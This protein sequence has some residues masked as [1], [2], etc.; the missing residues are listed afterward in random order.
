MKR[1][2]RM[3]GFLAMYLVITMCAAMLPV[4]AFAAEVVSQEIGGGE[5]TGLTAPEEGKM[6]F[7]TDFEATDALSVFNLYKN[8]SSTTDRGTIEL[9]SDEDSAHGQTVELVRKGRMGVRLG[10]DKSG[11]ALTVTSK[12]SS[13]VYEVDIKIK[14]LA[15]TNFTGW[16]RKP[17]TSGTGTSNKYSYIFSVENGK[18]KGRNSG[19]Y[20]ELASLNADTW[21]TIT[22]VQNYGTGYRD[23]Y[24]NGQRITTDNQLKIE[25]EYADGAADVNVF[26]IEC[27]E[28]AAA[29]YNAE[30]N[31]DAFRIDNLKI[32]EGTVPIA[33]TGGDGGDPGGDSGNQGGDGDQGGVTTT[34]RAPVEGTKLFLADFNEYN[35]FTIRTVGG[36]I[37]LV[38][39][40]DTSRGKVAEIQRTQTGDLR[41][42]ISGN[43]SAVATDASSVVYEFDLNLADLEATIFSFQLRKKVDG[44]SKYS[45]P[46]YVENGSLKIRNGAVAFDA[47]TPLQSLEKDTWY[48]IAIVQNYETGYRDVYVNGTKVSADNTFVIEPEYANGSTNGTTDVELARIECSSTTDHF[49]LD[50][51]R[52]YEG[53]APYTGEL[54]EKEV[55]EEKITIDLTKSVF[56]AEALKNLWGNE[57]LDTLLQGYV[58][59]HTRSGVVYHGGTKTVLDT[60][61]VK[62]DDGFLVVLEEIC[63]ALGLPSEVNGTTATVQGQSISVMHEDGKIWVNA[64]A[65]LG[66]YGTVVAD[67][68]ET[69]KS[70]G[71]L[72]AGSTAFSWPSSSDTAGADLKTLGSRSMLQNLNEY[73]FLE[74]PK[75]ADI[76]SLYEGSDVKGQHPRIQATAADFNKIKNEVQTNTQIN[77]WYQQLITA[78]DYLV[79]VNTTPLK[80]EFRDGVRLLYVSRDMLDHMYT[81]G[82]AYQLTGE[83]KYADRAWIDLEAVSKFQDWHPQHGLD[84]VEMSAAVAIGYDWM[85]HGL[86]QDQRSVVEKGM[87]NHCFTLACDGYQ[88]WG[89]TFSAAVLQDGN[90]NVVV[91]AGFLMG[92]LAFM[93]VYPEESAFITSGAIRAVEGMLIEFGPDGAWKEGPNY[94][95]Y[96]MQYTAKLL[97]TLDSVFGTCFSLDK[98]E[99]LSTAANYILDMQ[100]DRGLFDYGDSSPSHYYVPEIF[101]LSNKYDKAELSSTLMDLTQ[102]KMLD[103]ENV[104]LSMLW[105]DTAIS[106]IE[107]SLPLDNA[108]WSEG[109]ASFRD[110]W[111]EGATAYVGIHG[112]K[113]NV[114]HA[115]V[116]AGTFVYDYAGVRWA[117]EIGRTPYDTSVTSNRAEDS[118]RWLLYNSKAEAHNTLVI[119]PD[120]TAGQKINATAPL[121]RFENGNKGG[122][123]V[124]DLSENY[125]DHATSAIRG[126]FFT[127]DRTSLVVRDEITLSKADS[128]VYWFMQT[129]ADVEIAADGKSAI[130]SQSGQEMKLEYVTTGNGTA[131]LSFGPSTRALLGS[132]S[133]LAGTSEASKDVESPGVNRIA[134]KVSGASEDMT[135]TVKL[136]PKNAK[137]TALGEYNK[138]I[139]SWTIPEGEIAARP[140]VQSV[141]MDGR[142][143]VFD[144]AKKATFLCVEGAYNTIPSPMVTVDEAKFTYSVTNAETTDG[145]TVTILVKDKD[146]PEIVTSYTIVLEEIPVAVTPNG[147]AG[148]ALQVIAA[149]ASAEPEASNGYVAWK[150]L[151]QDT[152]SR[153]TSQGIANWILL[154]LEKESEVDNLVVL[155]KN[156][157]KR[158]TYFNVS[159]STDGENF[160]VIY[161]GASAGTMLGNEEAYEQFALGGV[162]AKYIKIGCNGNSAQG[163]ISGWNNIGEIVFTGTEKYVEPS[164]TPTPEAS[165]SP[166]PTPTPEA[167][168][169]PSPTPTPE[170]S[171]NPSPTPT[172]EASA[173]PSPTPTPE[174]S[175]SPSPKPTPEI[176]AEKTDE[177][178]VMGSDK[179]LR[180]YCTGLLSEFEKVEVDGILVENVHYTLEEGSTILT[181][182]PSYLETL[183]IGE[184][185]VRMSFTGE[186]YAIASIT[187]KAKSVENSNEAKEDNI[188]AEPGNSEDS[189]GT[190]GQEAAKT[191]TGDGSQITIWIAL[192]LF[193]SAMLI[194][195]GMIYRKHFHKR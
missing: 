146:N 49:L 19:S 7:Q 135:I 124:L 71:M 115:Q 190:A 48:T 80:Y 56:E 195:C 47:F 176:V 174:V 137:S 16:I 68:D 60:M 67:T 192:L 149:K 160:S 5:A 184:H 32:Y 116:D 57:Y 120:N 114:G 142:E 6:I 121:T 53:T 33:S 18:L 78:A 117:K 72:I 171:A 170:A 169:S 165:A 94:W 125:A 159:V 186:R 167:S 10:S 4:K 123:A 17:V 168:T 89:N 81:L 108:Y 145:G 153:W 85:Y 36:S 178:Y 30:T 140:E 98:C 44:L 1:R 106:G 183:S 83:Q 107:A 148:T 20:V 91:N 105:Y 73:L 79:N 39:N 157:H 155:F 82:M 166:S 3:A 24:L 50:N 12:A 64:E 119:N 58:A 102:G 191:L 87:Y 101:Y 127:D 55:D 99:G 100:S 134:L 182:K 31:T 90:Q 66:T 14:D 42:D 189:S 141:F 11:A 43:P 69:I 2:K 109:V 96:T 128:T 131:E 130:L 185:T 8:S 13:I 26:R 112:G 52:V 154:E 150:V 129:D 126:Y 97:S 25:G 172:P 132:T 110:K 46:C 181:F 41:L 173:S 63:Q 113:T 152:D 151:D 21:Y 28:I 75:V 35:P 194:V 77:S 84:V 111:T 188:K 37:N 180:I 38:D 22:V 59:L 74:Q 187:I 162:S 139:S 45:Y 76:T 88:D 65:L 92:A 158:S 143:I 15:A 164:P 163:I 138:A 54:L 27:A 29:N 9:V 147:F 122:I 34:L 156:G 51:V 177:S 136:T 161:S 70:N 133:P 144:D 104:V 179:T 193:M 95:E 62:T 175:A 61:P 93:D 118:G 103:C 23:I 40:A 86:T